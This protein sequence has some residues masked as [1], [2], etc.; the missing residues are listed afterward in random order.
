M[1]CFEGEILPGCGGRE[2]IFVQV[3]SFVQY[4]TGVGE[5]C[6]LP[7]WGMKWWAQILTVVT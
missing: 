4:F 3:G 7:M 5:T 1:R 2:D 6:G